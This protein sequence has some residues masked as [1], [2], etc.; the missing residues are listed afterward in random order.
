MM[1]KATDTSPQQLQ[2]AVLTVS[3]TRTPETDTS[4]QYLADEL[5]KLGHRLADKE[6][7]IDD[8]YLIRANVSVWIADHSVNAVLCTGGTG[9]RFCRWSGA[10]QK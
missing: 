4:G 7:V 2:I 1:S 9:F 3:D 10:Y 6:I 5:Q 8:I